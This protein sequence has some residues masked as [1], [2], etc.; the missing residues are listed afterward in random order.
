VLAGPVAGFGGVVPEPPAQDSVFQVDYANPGLTPSHWTLTIHPDGSGHFR[1]ERGAVTASGVQTIDAPDVDREIQLS[2]G[3]A[4]RVF[5]T[6]RQE[7]FF[8]VKC[9]SHLKVAFQGWKKFTYRGPDGEGSCAFN[10]S[11]EKE[12]QAL[13]ESLVSVAGTILAGARL[14]MLQL[15]D[16][17]GLDQE[18]EF[19]MEAMKDG[20][21]QQICA[22]RN[23]LQRLT[24]DPAVMERVRKRASVLLARAE[25]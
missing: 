24:E 8:A 9:E 4:K 14:E 19:L 13:G 11:Q 7:K 25:R 17:L 16:R 21:A 6:A 3:F 1:S 2:A 18:T 12:I 22:I 5:E 23:I 20:R 10:Y 15:H